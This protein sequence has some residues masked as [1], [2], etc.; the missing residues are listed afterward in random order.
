M[1]AGILLSGAFLVSRILGY[2]RTVVLG[3]TFGAGAELDAFFAAFRV[4]DLIFQVVAAGAMGS[5]LIPVLSGL[6]AGDERARAWR[7][8]ATVSN[9]LLVALTVLAVAAFVGAP[10]LV[11][12]LAP[13]FDEAGL[14]RTTELTRIMLASPILLAL[15]A[16]A[17]SSLNAE[18]RFAAAALAPIVYNLGIIGGAVILG[19]SMGV[20]GLAI[21]VVVGAAG[22]LAIQLRPLFGLGFRPGLWI[23]L[24]DPAARRVLTLLAP[25]AL[26]LGASQITFIV[27]TALASS[28]GEGAVSA[29]AIAF[30]LLQIPIG[31]L[32]VP[33]GTIIFPS[34]SRGHA[35]GA[36]DEFVGLVTRSVRILVF[37]MVPIAALGIALRTPIVELLF[38]YGKFDAAAIDRTAG[39]LA[40][41]LFG[42]PAHAAIAVLARAFYARQDT[43]TPVLAAVAAVAINVGI[44][45][46]LVR[47]LGLPGL[48]AA[49]AIAAWIEAALLLV[50]LGRHVPSF[51]PLGVLRI[52]AES[53]AGALLAAIA[54]TLAAGALAGLLAPGSDKLTLLVGTVAVTLAGLAVYAALAVALRIPELPSIVG[55]VTD[56]IRRR[57]RA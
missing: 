13:G 43:R 11:R 20:A 8:V 27:M 2:V 7:V 3:T 45:I 10:L 42:L 29:Y 30:A 40:A 25:R 18:G 32:G 12:V 28:L 44:G 1:R 39:S 46:L 54:A 23:D 4:P 38:G 21:G 47:P 50:V 55:I 37:V 34:I 48:A 19:P 6:L 41:F 53:G 36:V 49:I 24:A 35:L 57:R 5:A 33:L 14:A 15:G 31:V 16:V 26:G 52:L 17:T 56:Q 51:D 9:L 22:H